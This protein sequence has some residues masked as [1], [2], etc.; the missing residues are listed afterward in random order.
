MSDQMPRTDWCRRARINDRSR[1]RDHLKIADEAFIVWNAGRQHAFE[2]IDRVGEGVVVAFIDAVA[3]L[4]CRAGVVDRDSLVRH[5]DR[6]TDF[7]PLACT[8]GFD[9]TMVGAGFDLPD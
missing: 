4:R 8:V 3:D 2:W 5:R 9:T 1:R 7:D 6:N